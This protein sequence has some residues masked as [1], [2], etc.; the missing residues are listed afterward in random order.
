VGRLLAALAAAVPPG[1]RILEMGTGVGVGTAWIVH[2]LTGRDDVGVV[3]V[4]IDPG[5]SAIARRGT[6]PPFVTLQVGD[7]LDLLGPLGRFDLIFADSQGGKWSGLDRTIQAVRPGGI[8][9]VDDMR[10]PAWLNDE[11][12]VNTARVR[13]TLLTHPDLITA[14]LAEASGMMLATRRRS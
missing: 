3:S 11:H 4:E 8:L 5:V 10:P 7:I 6:W 13:A 14:E 12:R 1:G 2:G 9:L